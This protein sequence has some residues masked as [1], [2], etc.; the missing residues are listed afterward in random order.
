MLKGS[1][2]DDTRDTAR[3]KDSTR[4]T[5]SRPSQGVYIWQSAAS[6]ETQHSEKSGAGRQMC[7]EERQ[8]KE[9]KN[10]T[11]RGFSRVKLLFI[12]EV[13]YSVVIGT[14]LKANG[15]TLWEDVP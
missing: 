10:L 4:S 2:F 8:N 11:Q 7:E 6:S 12:W 9:K 1:Q 3:S 13:H 14:H 5:V 15:G